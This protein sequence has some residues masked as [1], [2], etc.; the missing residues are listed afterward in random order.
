[1]N[2][3]AIL[4]GRDLLGRQAEVATVLLPEATIL[5]QLAHG[6]ARDSAERTP[7]LQIFDHHK[8]PGL[9]VEVRWRTGGQFQNDA[10][11]FGVDLPVGK[12]A[13]G[14]MSLANG[15]VEI[16]GYLMVKG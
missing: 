15:F 14:G 3:N 9:R 2:M 1:V 5:H 16:H 13:V 10:L 6:L 7:P 11:A 4:A 8:A 12:G